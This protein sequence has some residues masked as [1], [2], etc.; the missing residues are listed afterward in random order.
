MMPLDPTEEITQ[1]RSR[2]RR[3]AILDAPGA[4]LLGVALYGKFGADGEAFHPLL[5]DPT[6]TTGMAIIGGIIVAWGAAQT[7]S[8]TKRIANIERS[9]RT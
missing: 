2:L 3:V 4:I 1:L 6:V 9:L 7:I 5:N 8:I